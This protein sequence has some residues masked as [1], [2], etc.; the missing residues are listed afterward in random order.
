MYIE[1]EKTERERERDRESG[2]VRV[3]KRDSEKR[4]CL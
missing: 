2:G 3:E 4:S 1:R